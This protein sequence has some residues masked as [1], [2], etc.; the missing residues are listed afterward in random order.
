MTLSTG[1]IKACNL[2]FQSGRL[3]FD[4][5]TI[6]FDKIFTQLNA[7]VNT[8]LRLRG[9]LLDYGERLSRG[10]DDQAVVNVVTGSE[11]VQGRH[12]HGARY[13]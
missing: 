3:Q 8:D 9:R 7:G 5:E 4:T 11:M 13:F 6:E 2:F 1:Y 12:A 10:L